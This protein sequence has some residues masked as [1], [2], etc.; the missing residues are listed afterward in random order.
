[1]N[2]AYTIRTTMEKEIESLII[3]YSWVVI[4]IP[5]FT[6][7]LHFKK[8]KKGVRYFFFF[9]VFGTFTEIITHIAI[10]YI[11]K[12]NNSMP[13]GHFYIAGS[14]LLV[15]LF[16]YYYLKGFVKKNILSGL[17]IL[18]E[19]FAIINIIFFQ[20]I[21][22]F[23]SLSG[24][25]GA[26]LLITFSILLFARIMAE[27]KIKRLIDEPIIWLNSA[28]LIYY[29]SNFFF[30]ILYNINLSNSLEFSKLTIFIFRFFNTV[31]YVLVA[32]GFLKTRKA[33]R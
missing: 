29:T 24:A 25:V 33:A 30:Y 22:S 6:G 2:R 17:I 9:V 27:G 31:F 11:D 21:F 7:I 14:I 20:N 19:L 32:T 12:I 8:M 26:L 18:F 28:V 10:Y 4:F 1:M 5:L 3:K 23:P 13:I 16:Y 15:S